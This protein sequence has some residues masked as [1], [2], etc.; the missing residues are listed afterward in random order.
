M[1]SRF[2]RIFILLFVGLIPFSWVKAQNST[3][4]PDSVCTGS[5]EFYRVDS[6]DGSYFLWGTKY[7]SGTITYLYNDSSAHIQVTWG[8][9]VGIDTLWVIETNEYGCPGDTNKLGVVRFSNP[10]ATIPIS[11]LSVC[12]G[13]T[14]NLT[15]NVSGLSPY[16]F[17][18][19]Q[20]GVILPTQTNQ[21]L[22]IN[23]VDATHAGSYTCVVSNS[24]G[25]TTSN[26]CN[27]TILFNPVITLLSSPVS[28][29][30]GENITIHV[31]TT[32]SQPL[33]F[34]WYHGATPLVNNPPHITGAT[35]SILTITG[36]TYSDTGYYHCIISNTCAMAITDSVLVNINIAPVIT[37]Q[38]DSLSICNNQNAQ[39]TVS[40]SGDSL[41][42]QW[43][44]NGVDIV[45]ATNDTLSFTPATYLD[46]ANYQCIV[47][48]TCG[49]EISLIAN[50][51]MNIPP[52]II[53]NPDSV[54]ICDGQNTFFTVIASGDSLHY[55]WRKNGVNI[56]G[57]TNSTLNF[58]PAHY[59]DTGNY[60]CV[61][62]NNCGTDTSANAHL[63][64]NIPPAI[65]TQPHNLSKCLGQD[66][67]FSVI[68]SGDS[69][70]FQWLKNGNLIPGASQSTLILNNIQYSDTASY[71]CH[72]WN[73]C[74]E[75]YS[76]AGV[77]NINILP[78]I[79]VQPN[80][81]SSCLGDSV[82]LYVVAAGDSLKYQ[83]RL[84]GID[85]SGAIQSSITIN[86]VT[87]AN[88]GDYTCWVYNNC[89]GV[90]SNVATLSVNLVPHIV[91]QP[92]KISSCPGYSATFSVTATGDS[93][94]YQ[95]MRN[96]VILPGETNDSLTINPV[97][98][99]DTASY[100]CLVSN[101]C[102]SELSTPAKLTIN[103]PPVITV[104][105][106]NISTCIGSSITLNISATGDSLYY[107]WKFNG[108]DIPGAIQSS[109]TINP[110]QYSDTG[111][112][113]C[114]V[115]NTCG[116]VTSQQAHVTINIA[117]VIVQQP[118]KISTCP[119]EN[120]SFNVI[121]TGDSLYYQWKKNGF[122]IPGA[123]QN[124]LIFNPVSYAD[125]A[126][127]T[128][129]IYNTCGNILSETVYLNINIAPVIQQQ[130][131][132]LLSCVGDM[133][134][135]H[136]DV[137][138]DS[139]NYQWRFEGSNIIG[140]NS[141][142]YI[143][144]P[145]TLADIGVYDV[146]VWN[147]CGTVISD[148]AHLYANIDPAIIVNPED[149][150]SCLGQTESFIVGIIAA[151]SALPNFQWY[152]DG[153]VLTGE[154]DSVLTISN[155]TL[156]KTGAYFCEL[157]NNCDTVYTDI[158]Y[159]TVNIAPQIVQQPNSIS[160]CIGN[161]EQF[162][163]VASGDSLYYQWFKDG[164]PLPGATDSIL[165]FDPVQASHIGI[166]YCHIWN[167]C[168]SINSQPVSLYMNIP[169]AITLQPINQKACTGDNVILQVAATGDYINYQ[170]FK[171]GDPI[172]GATSSTLQF[173]PIDYS[174]RGQYQCRIQNNC[175]TVW[176]NTVWIWVNTAPIITQQPQGISTCEGE[177][178]TLSVTA[179]GD[180][181]SYQWQL[182][183]IDI[184]GATSNTYTIYNI[185]YS[186]TGNYTCYMSTR[187]GNTMTQ[188]AKV[189]VNRV[190][191]IT[192]QPSNISSC[193][194]DFV[195]INFGVTGD[196]LQYQWYKN[197]N[198]MV[199]A[200]NAS[201]EFPAINVD[202]RGIYRC[203][204]FNTCGE[205]WTISVNVW[206]NI[207]P[208][209][210]VQPN[211]Q[212]RCENDSVSF[213]ITPIGDSIS[214]Q[215]YHNNQPI[216]G[217]TDSIY[218]I[219]VVA[220]A[221]AGTYFCRVTSASCGFYDSDIVTLDV[222]QKFSIHALTTNISC[223]G[224]SD[225]AIDLTLVNATQPVQYQWSNGATSEDLTGL[226][227]GF[228]SVYII[229]YN[230]CREKKTIEIDE[231]D[232]LAFVHDT[233]IF[234]NVLRQGGPGNDM[235]MAIKTDKLGNTYVTGKF[236]GTANFQTQT[237]TSFGLDDIFL[238]KY[239]AAGN[240][241]WIRQA[242]GSLQD[243]GHDLAL[244]SLGNIYLT[245]SFQ[246]MA[247]FGS[248]QILANGNKDI[249]LAK[250]DNNGNLFWVKNFGGFFDDAGNS[251]VTTE[252]GYSWLAGSMQGIATFQDSTIISYGGDDAFLA[253]FNPN[254]E[255]Q[256]V[257][258]AGGT[259]EDFAYAVTIDIAEDAIITGRFQSTA[260]FGSTSLISSG[261]NDIFLAKYDPIGN[262]KWV[263]K[264]GGTG[265]DLSRAVK[266]DYSQ[267]IYLGGSIEGNANFG[268]LNATSQGLKDAFVAKY[269]KDGYPQWIRTIGG[270]GI[271]NSKDLDVDALGNTYI[272]G[273]FRNNITLG[274]KTL[275]S[276][277]SSD[278]Y[279]AKY[280]TSGYL[281]WSQ[282][283]GGIGA[284]SAMAIALRYDKNLA[285]GGSF[286]NEAAF[287]G[288]SL[289]SQG[290]D[291][292]FL[293]RLNQV[294][295]PTPPE[296]ENALCFNGNEG[297]INLTVGG[298]TLPYEF[299]WSTGA[300]TEDLTNIPAGT[301]W[302]FINDANN[303]ELDEQ[304]I[305][306]SQYPFPNP[307]I[308]ASVNRDYFCTNDPGDIVLSADG[309][310]GDVLNW[311][312]DSCG[313]VPIGSGSP[314]TIPSPTVTT[315]YY[316]RWENA[317]GA[318]LCASVEVHV[319]DLPLPPSSVSVNQNPICEGTEYITL[320]ATGGLGEILK[321]YSDSCG[322]I[323]VGT[324]T[325][326]TIPAPTS[327]TT[328][329]A[330]WESICGS[331]ECD[332]I[333]IDVTPLPQPVAQITASTDTICVNNTNPITL[334]ATGGSGD[335]LN[336][337]INTCNGTVIGTGYSILIDPPS[338][339]TT[340]YAYWE[341]SCGTSACASITI[342][343]IP[344][345]V[346]PT[347][348][349]VSNNFFC[350]GTVPNITLTAIGGDGEEVRWFTGYCGSTNIIGT[351]TS[352]TI[353]SP[354]ETTVYYARWENACGVSACAFTTVTVYPE[355]VVF[356][357]GLE[358][359]YCINS[360]NALLTGNHAP[361][362]Y[363]SGP[364]VINNGDGTAWFSPSIAGTGG[365][366]TITYTYTSPQ[367]CSKSSSQTTIVRALPLVNFVGLSNSYCVNA[368]PAL[369]T[370]N[371]APQGTFSGPGITN[372]GNG[373]AMFDPAVAGVG[374]PY[375]IIYTYSDNWG[376]ENS[377]TKSV[378]VYALPVV[379]FSGLA[380]QYCVN[381]NPATLTG[382]QAPDGFFSGIGITN[383]GLGQAI[384]DPAAAGVG[385]PYTITY[386]YTDPYG[387]SNTKSKT[388][389]V[390]ALPTASF[391]GLNVDYCLNDQQDTLIGSMLPFGTF[392]GPGITDNNN[393]T[394]FFKPSVAGAGGPYTITYSYTDPNGCSASQSQTTIVYPLPQVSFT[395]L[396][397]MYCVNANPVLLTGNH[398]PFGE[399]SGPGI[400]DH[401]N[402]TAT[403]DP[404]VAGVGTHQITYTYTNTNGCINSQTKTVVINALP[405]ISFT[406][407]EEI[408]CINDPFDILT[409][410]QAPFGTFT[411][412][413]ILDLGNGKARF[414]PDQAGIGGPYPI[415]YTYIDNNACSGTYTDSTSVID[416]PQ[417]SVS[418]LEPSYCIDAT[419]DT[420]VGNFE[421][422][423]S[424]SGP[425]IIDLNIGK[426]IFDPSL[427]G[428]GGPY[429][430]TY[431]YTDPNGCSNEISIEVT[432]HPLPEVTFNT[433]EPGY[434]INANPVILV[435]NYKPYG[436]FSGTGVTDYGNG[437]GLFTPSTA[438]VG[439]PYDIT[440]EYTDPN[441]CYASQTQSTYV[442]P[443]PTTPDS[444][445]ASA[446][447]FCTGTVPNI[448]LSV[449]GGSGDIV[450][451]FSA[452]CGGT[453]IGTGTS[454]VIPSPADTTLYFARWENQ[455][456][457]SECDSI[458]I[459]IIHYPVEPDLVFAS[460]NN[461]CSTSIDSLTLTAVGGL[462]QVFHWYADSCGLNLIG[463]GSP[464][465]IAAPLATT[466]YF[467]RWETACGP[468]NCKEVTVTVHPLPVI[469]DSITA[470]HNNFCQGAYTN[471]TLTAWGGQ[472]DYLEWYAD[473]CGSTP[474]GSG[475]PLVIPAPD[476][477][478]TYFA[479]WMN[480][481][482]TTE[483]QSVIVNVMPAAIAPD[484][485]SVDQNN[486]CAGTVGFITLSAFG[487][488]GDTLQW[489]EGECGENYI[490]SGNSLLI[491][492]PTETT[493][494]YARYANNCGP[495]E[496]TSL[497]VNVIP[498]PL[499]TDSLT[500]DTNFFCQAY[501]GII[502]L[503]GFGGIG[504]TLRWYAGSCGSNY[505][506]K[507]TELRI[508]APDTTT[509]YFARWTNACGESECDSIKVVVDEPLPLDSVWVDK[510]IVCFDDPGK[511]HLY[512]SGG[513]G[514]N[515]YWFANHCGTTPIGSGTSLQI[516]SPTVTTTY[517]A[518]WENHCGESVCDSVQVLVIPKATPPALIT[519]DTNYFCP[520]T[521]AQITLKA[522]GG[523]GDTLSGFGDTL[524]WFI[525]KCNGVEI[526]TGDSLTIPAP[527]KTTTYYAR[528]E[529]HCSESECLAFTVVVDVP[530][531]VTYIWADTN[532][533]CQGQVE[534]ITLMAYG[535]YGEF[536][537][538]YK[539][540]N[541]AYQL[542]V[543]GQPYNFLAPD[544]TTTYYVRWENHCGVS[545]WDSI[546]IKVNT[547]VVPPL[548]T[549]DTNGFCSD[550][551]API[552]LGGIGGNGDT[553]RWFTSS[554]G[555]NEIGIGNPLSI[556]A[557]TQTTTYYA[558]YENICG[559]TECNS[560]TVDVVPAPII[561]AGG[562][563][564]VCERGAYKIINAHAENYSNI[565]WT[566]TGSGI[567]DNPASLNP[568]YTLSNDEVIDK[569]TVYLIMN[570]NG[571]SPC[572]IYSDTLTL[573]INPLPVLSIF[574]Y[575]TAICR[576]SSILITTSGAP[577]YEWRPTTGLK[578]I[579]NQN[580][581]L[582]PTQPTTYTLIGTSAS[583]CVDSINYK[584]DV[585][586]TPYVDLGQDLYLFN[587]EPVVLD[588]GGGSLD[589]SYE[590]QDGSRQRFYKATEN[591]TYWV[592]VS[593][594]G[595]YTIDTIQVQLCEGYVWAP[596]AF[597]PNSDGLNETFKIITSD[598]TINFQMYIYSRSGMLVYETD[599]ITKGWDGKDMNGELCPSGVYVW[600]I[601]YKGN[602]PTSPGIEFTRSGVVTL[603]R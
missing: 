309:G 418:G 208:G 126:N 118:V 365:P 528:W 397:P 551:G 248:T 375:Q 12:E 229:D 440:Y 49:T 416:I 128:C 84:N 201:L 188:Q 38:P 215:W 542:L 354:T 327:P 494:F 140:A 235:I 109:L 420:I 382:N 151:G 330:R 293:T 395:G 184:P 291:D 186:Q 434:C 87:L 380:P 237:L 547:P 145:V 424:F 477:T 469:M 437:T 124:T 433:L 136:I 33:S 294:A 448:T 575:D 98:Y 62:S 576:D 59:S 496:C 571:N 31:S 599:D 178:Y 335:V 461:F 484:S 183:G 432:V 174:A 555:G 379:D 513:Y 346:A 158:V 39:F 36:M 276:I 353:P 66:A 446:N 553:L 112:Y 147:N 568:T 196:S 516:N 391:T 384:F 560:I 75:I 282:Q 559:I 167:T 406:G 488:F 574:P 187:C 20:N 24:C 21:N 133:D 6:T 142:N 258:H 86:P 497:T 573:L 314:L 221:D 321:W 159:L 193:E 232:P 341:N 7:A 97:T 298:G 505:V 108:I 449:I 463:S 544:T 552:Y 427:A 16:S 155:I 22:I 243:Q 85:I 244:D 130:P 425:G 26:A 409:G 310:S 285:L 47:Y 561:F 261:N 578:K 13:T 301:Y 116:S 275:T 411:G 260:Q 154:N 387:C 185:Q 289:I 548:L 545:A 328:Y 459:N 413:G 164:N 506:G 69:L 230:N 214:L 531:P 105:P 591:G 227:P 451:W 45:G 202:D 562:L 113:S 351:G 453:E 589:V 349:T 417:L 348:I 509:W 146:I 268:T 530:M 511:I 4:Q 337:T 177:N 37:Q 32:G 277:G 56:A 222:V 94:E 119:G 373:T 223:N 602:S 429:T 83:W 394:A 3:I 415:T 160:T 401:F 507:G 423:G 234:S 169:P 535:G 287:G 9:T 340:Y 493:T 455:C 439:G 283:A 342:Y 558:R 163:V 79:T 581:L 274:R 430:I 270:T 55:Q 396:N 242:G 368:A 533:Y 150:S 479:R 104:Q 565:L 580:Y 138:G 50:L 462:G 171:D 253:R 408:Y 182:E 307:P 278:I 526:G 115:Y 192:Q 495:S 211:S 129:Q 156:A 480:G 96:G 290:G 536:L 388:V 264:A 132:S 410:S 389:T 224:A 121:A 343:V 58:I 472:G 474:L 114:D 233:T 539:W 378:I 267:N 299:F 352:V 362:G 422:M 363:F 369:L 502:I 306:E 41:Y 203:H 91:V 11:T 302:V 137:T 478:T 331:S 311:Y 107:Q 512:A 442:Y 254:G 426:A 296:I 207:L 236:Q 364:G 537:R 256:W 88:T 399:F 176:S 43:Q 57:A 225:G 255:L 323:E 106:H 590:W 421:P 336:W 482:D 246:V 456:G 213:R 100:T 508:S 102:G 447:N 53:N 68:A 205:A 157:S 486:Y 206:V 266:T 173:N 15:V 72:I 250:Y 297:S 125:T 259:S 414:Y 499:M 181:I 141:E 320:M 404:S 325:P 412:P 80:K 60:V 318:S 376:C 117:P 579:D 344:N 492:A 550:Y 265:N 308:S 521:V 390:N 170:W 522:F 445:H 582:S 603:I 210:V 540:E 374:G 168:G 324:G 407:L 436:A 465:T 81:T 5:T 458:Q 398:A 524:R 367:G 54:S 52:Q 527:M 284:D 371:M 491:N 286:S 30:L 263:H 10:E 46:T 139:L 454:I 89:G 372:L 70:N 99:N 251:I 595:C 577:N 556:P 231:P 73:N 120:V 216:L 8:N 63:N 23:N 518:R 322:G 572:G 180:S 25:N 467:G 209:V 567:F 541:G 570:V 532:N 366:Y 476:S 450:R 471:L 347:Q 279:V 111:Y 262:L 597:S 92:Q 162:I 360:S 131:Q 583:G 245:G 586:S 329:Y 483:C 592:K 333:T 554:C 487:G 110:V 319:I 101:T 386:T 153:L 473:A 67:T 17:Q 217:A 2:L 190:P 468:S 82:T 18:W 392:T 199:G 598:E 238:A 165:Q 316:A 357:T 500:V 148:T 281:V 361:D 93:L 103:I 77:L 481:C 271:D 1:K 441:G 303:C 95:W 381:A 71:V 501:N 519:V 161:T 315:T 515:I 464:L 195:S 134:Y 65:V 27:V 312:S 14:L 226:A 405:N 288:F 345:P 61:I 431:S 252:G 198:P 28:T 280:N 588:A 600:K 587:C 470:N 64:M 393:G 444:L 377:E 596:T 241:S 228:Y 175:G 189:T 272:A 475:S 152:K 218:Q 402:G 383:I 317:C 74:G 534:D 29:C 498:Q 269:S 239:N 460:E 523:Y 326:L 144:N 563:D 240:L 273:T 334:T 257:K 359:N 212:T 403:F 197:G 51:N 452:A 338:V 584:L 585:Y 48:N 419:P 517:F 594:R 601:I 514:D 204:I 313:G 466:T 457:V 358:P 490:G 172:L 305:I 35:D 385:G 40:A 42:Y 543:T 593:N 219:P 538:W 510:P 504:D 191:V 200:T 247:F 304:F 546:I 249:F 443:L 428:V 122:D 76:N 123:T 127:Y 19:Y 332:S 566:T 339:T 90:L 135:F 179:L 356:F 569:D 44:K 143:I 549:V 503:N 557:P 435:G 529:N 370:G 295:V 400:T 34:Q 489:F 220:L 525:D 194:G 438:G 166:Y 300:T 564:S 149:I 520:N 350:F 292:A 355:P 78:V 485:I